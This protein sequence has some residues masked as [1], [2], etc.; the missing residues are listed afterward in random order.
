M[1]ER[2]DEE[3]AEVKLPEVVVVEPT[4]EEQD[5]EQSVEDTAKEDTLVPIPEEV[6]TAPLEGEQKA[7]GSTEAGS[8]VSS[9]LVSQIGNCMPTN[10]CSHQL[11]PNIFISKMPSLVKVG[12]H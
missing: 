12:T 10:G 5:E 3:P 1:D 9:G 2:Q 4:D 7:H 6:L 11:M 8:F